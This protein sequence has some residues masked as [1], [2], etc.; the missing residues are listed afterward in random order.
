[1][2]H[3]TAVQR[4]VIQ[5]LQGFNALRATLVRMRATKNPTDADAIARLAKKV[6]TTFGSVNKTIKALIDTRLI[7]QAELDACYIA[8]LKQP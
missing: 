7:T 3:H 6:D 5:K 8:A 1:M 4:H 2:T